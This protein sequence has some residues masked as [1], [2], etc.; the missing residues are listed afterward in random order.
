MGWTIFVDFSNQKYLINPLTVLTIKTDYIN[1]YYPG[2]NQ[3]GAIFF[4]QTTTR[5]ASNSD[6]CLYCLEDDSDSL[7]EEQAKAFEDVRIITLEA[8]DSE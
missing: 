2:D 8:E 6:Q 7:T 1:Y 4:G 3:C 5:V